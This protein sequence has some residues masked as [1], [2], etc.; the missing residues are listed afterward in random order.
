[1]VLLLCLSI[2]NTLFAISELERINGK[3]TNLT[4]EKSAVLQELNDIDSAIK[5]VSYSDELSESK[6]LH[7]EKR[8]GENQDFKAFERLEFLGDSVLGLVVA[9]LLFNKNIN[10]KE[11]DLSNK[12]SYLVQ[13]N[14]LYNV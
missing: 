2:I 4:L 3:T 11:G 10:Q 7:K 14:F 9:A 12:Y 5:R 13:K 8:G 1:M 6:K